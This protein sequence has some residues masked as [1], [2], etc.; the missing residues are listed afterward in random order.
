MTSA[1][2]LM[3]TGR[4]EG[5]QLLR[6]DVT[7]V[8]Q[9]V[10]AAQGRRTS[11][12]YHAAGFRKEPRSASPGM[13]RHAFAACPFYNPRSSSNLSPLQ[14]LVFRQTVYGNTTCCTPP[15]AAPPLRARLFVFRRCPSFLVRLPATCSAFAP[16]RTAFASVH[17]PPTA[18]F[19]GTARTVCLLSC[20]RRN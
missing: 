3:P 17:W 1:Q 16:W 20:E 19:A 11:A 10:S 5:S 14:F 4:H 12:T 8:G 9:G 2:F 15:S 6:L 18:R 13:M 7:F